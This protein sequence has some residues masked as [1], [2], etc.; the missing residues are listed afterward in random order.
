MNCCSTIQF[1]FNELSVY[2]CE[3]MFIIFPWKMA[4]QFHFI[5]AF[6]NDII[7][8]EVLCTVCYYIYSNSIF[9]WDKVV[10]W[11][12]IRFR[13]LFLIKT[14]HWDFWLEILSPN[15]VVHSEI[16]LG[17]SCRKWFTVLRFRFLPDGLSPTC[18]HQ[19]YS[20]CLS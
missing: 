12:L 17:V 2:F 18:Y 15:C 3:C 1:S 6:F 9:V 5:E 19:W 10:N 4:Y 11:K 16:L 7:R 13:P 14:M 20:K 8:S